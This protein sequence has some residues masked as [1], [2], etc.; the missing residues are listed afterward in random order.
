MKLGLKIALLGVILFFSDCKKKDK[1]PVG[2]PA[3]TPV[4]NPPQTI[5]I[6]HRTIVQF[7]ADNKTYSYQFNDVSDTIRWDFGFNTELATSMSGTSTAEYSHYFYNYNTGSIFFKVDIGTIFTKGIVGRP[8][9]AALRLFFATG[10]VIYSTAYTPDHLNGVVI[11][12]KDGNGVMWASNKGSSDQT[13]S[14]FNIVSNRQVPSLPD[15][16]KIYATFNCKVYDDNGNSKDLTN[17]KL[18]VSFA[19]R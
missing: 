12:H 3:P 17:G 2:E 4:P 16:M 18:V 6:N 14:S 10:P 7:D 1:D 5:D 8:D 15:E 13:G 11:K 9:T 19:N